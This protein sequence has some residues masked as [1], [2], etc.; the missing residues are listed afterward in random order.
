MN[1]QKHYINLIVA[2][3]LIFG[4][5]AVPLQQIAFAEEDSPNTQDA[6]DAAMPPPILEFNGLDRV[7][8]DPGGTDPETVFPDTTGAAGH[9]HYLQ[10]VNKAIALYTKGGTQIEAVDFNTFW[11]PVLKFI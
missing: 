6:V 3:L 2:V 10:A 4:L 8:F 9:T 1:K 5:L 11:A 7:D